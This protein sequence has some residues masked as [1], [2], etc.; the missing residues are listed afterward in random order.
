MDSAGRDQIGDDVIYQHALERAKSAP[1]MRAHWKRHWLTFENG[2]HLELHDDGSTHEW[3]PLRHDMEAT[4]WIDA[5]KAADD[6]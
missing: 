6:L 5:P 3:C 4:D 2:Q 1:V